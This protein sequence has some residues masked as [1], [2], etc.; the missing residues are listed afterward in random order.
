VLAPHSSHLILGGARSGKS[1]RAQEIAGRHERVAVVATA[2]ALD[3][4]MAA[5]IAR[6]RAERPSGWVTVES[7]FDPVGACRLLAGSV[8]VAIIDC[9][10]LWVSNRLLR[11]DDAEAIL[12]DAAALGVLCRE[13]AL[14]LVIVSNEVGEGVHP[15]TREGLRFRDLLGLVNQRV[16]EAADRVTLM[17]AGIPLAV[18]DETPGL[19]LAPDPGATA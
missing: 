9:L 7:P 13:R 19:R 14:S 2:E 6:H 3:D 16:A 4:D 11:G 8:D 12:A 18:K 15:E 5:R 1:R 17:V 10:T